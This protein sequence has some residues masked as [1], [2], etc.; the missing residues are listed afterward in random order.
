[1]QRFAVSY[2]EDGFSD[3]RYKQYGFET[4][5]HWIREIV[6]NIPTS[7]SAEDDDDN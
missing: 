1:M 5:S 2:L 6:K 4:P 3:P 7:P